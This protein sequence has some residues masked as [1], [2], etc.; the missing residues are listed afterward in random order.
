LKPHL[1]EQEA[2]GPSGLALLGLDLPG[3][4][5]GRIGHFK[6]TFISLCFY[7]YFLLKNKFYVLGESINFLKFLDVD[8]CF[9]RKL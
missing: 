3:D 1:E 7:F 4:M 8:S 2:L 6:A 5:V 9:K